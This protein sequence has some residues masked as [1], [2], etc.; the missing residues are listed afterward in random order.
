M[1]DTERP[2]RRAAKKRMDDDFVYG[3]L[4]AGCCRA[5]L[6]ST[7]GMA[8]CARCS[9]WF[10]GG[11]VRDAAAV[12]GA[13]DWLCAGCSPDTAT[14]Q[15]AKRKAADGKE[16]RK[17]L[18]LTPPSGGS[19]AAEAAD[20]AR[21]ASTPAVM[22]PP[23]SKASAAPRMSRSGAGKKAGRG[24]KAPMM[25]AGAAST[26][27]DDDVVL[28]AAL[29]L[30]N[31]PGTDAD[32]AAA[33]DAAATA[34]AAATLAG[35]P[36]AADAPRAAA[37][38][39]AALAPS[40]TAT[41]RR[42]L[43]G[44]DQHALMTLE[45]LRAAAAQLTP[46]CSPTKAKRRR[47]ARGAQAGGNGAGS[48]AL[49]GL[50]HHAAGRRGS[51]AAVDVCPNRDNPAH[52]CTAYCFW[53]WQAKNEALA[54]FHAERAQ[55]QQLAD[56]ADDDDDDDA[57]MRDDEDEDGG[58]GPV[59]PAPED[60]EEAYDQP[61]DRAEHK[62]IFH[63]QRERMRRSTIR[64]LFEELRK[65]VPAVE[66]QDGTSDRQILTEAASHIHDLASE[67]R[68]LEAAIIG[69]RIDNLKLRLQNQRAAGN[70]DSS[71]EESLA[72]VMAGAAEIARLQAEQQQHLQQLD[73]SPDQDQ[74]AKPK[75]KRRP[76]SGS[77]DP[78]RPAFV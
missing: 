35:V 37:E 31:R 50:A 63:N 71:L 70:S 40:G 9:D 21:P 77:S 13:R 49:S 61:H 27:F 3:N 28:A 72:V 17:R 34:A 32:A 57:G 47:A 46:P 18:K 62:R 1:D 73:D 8:Q 2:R 23:A 43:T 30:L 22:P 12:P 41:P 15:P 33:A 20:E 53:R 5:T 42:E 36:Q 48:S 11:C 69:L 65:C 75:P 54:Q 64:Q 6:A 14:P 44:L 74:P 25:G 55:H 10:H 24:G 4:V 78:A 16:P 45:L 39:L 76:A 60:D 52:E 67:S 26:R 66:G 56:G 38:A 51:T 58:D 68:E 7:A 29:A 19:G 59:F